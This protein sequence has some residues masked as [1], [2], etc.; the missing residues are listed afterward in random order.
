MPVK[1]TS[2]A[3]CCDLH[4]TAATLV[5]QTFT[6]TQALSGYMHAPC[7]NTAAS[8]FGDKHRGQVSA[9]VQKAKAQLKQSA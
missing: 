9:D 7:I 3:E 4:V 6:N 2:T 1:V 8:M 5:T